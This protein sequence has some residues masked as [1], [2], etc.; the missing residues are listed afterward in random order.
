MALRRAAG[1]LRAS[2]AME[3]GG[4]VTRAAAGP[5]T[6]P[7]RVTFS[8]MTPP[9]PPWLAAWTAV[10]LRRCTGGKLLPPPLS[11]LGPLLLPPPLPV[12]LASRFWRDAAAACWAA[13]TGWPRAAWAAL[14]RTGPGA[15]G[16]GS[17]P[18]PDVSDAQSRRRGI[19][20]GHPR[21]LGP[22]TGHPGLEGGRCR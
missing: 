1:A 13:Q 20:R 10:S 6:P 4:G 22:P 16:A 12:S 8:S 11:V 9:G 2:A 19:R 7:W 17:S 5:V 14:L 21:R 18:H 3:T 15:S